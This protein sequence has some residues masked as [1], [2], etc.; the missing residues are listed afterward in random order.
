VPNDVVAER[1]PRLLQVAVGSE[2]DEVGRLIAV[3]LVPLHE[4]ELDGGCH[5][6]LLEVLAAEG[7]ARREELDLVVVAGAVVL[8]HVWRIATPGVC[9]VRPRS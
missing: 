7:V 2:L 6:A 9:A 8:F 1:A 4:A 3:E 5:D